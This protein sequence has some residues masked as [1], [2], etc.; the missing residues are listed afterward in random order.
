MSARLLDGRLIATDV[1][2]DLVSLAREYAQRH[3]RPAG[4]AIVEV[5]EHPSARVYARALVRAAESVGVQTSRIHLASS[6]S[7]HELRAVM[8]TLSTDASVQGILLVTPVPPQIGQAAIADV[9]A[10][11]KDVDG[12]S[13]RNA[14]N[15]FLSFPT[16]VP[17]TC[18]AVLELL[19]RAH[20]P[21]A[22][23]RVVVVGASNVVGKPLAYLLLQR[24]ATVTVCHV[25]TRNLP[26]L[27]RQAE[28]V[29]VAVGKPGIL[30]GEMIAPGAVVVDVGISVQADGSILGDVDT[31]SVLPVAGAL[32]PVPGGVGQLTNLMVLQQTLRSDA[33]AALP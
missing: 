11:N 5:G 21:L 7:E 13:F 28:I 25:H 19:D 3:G 17:S 16:F 31:A 4:L 33:L 29:V 8:L 10:P 30:T 22:G 27:T 18:A 26:K 24:D 12:I 6:A 20:I 15:L 14:G 2:A 32:T 23:K 1:R 9:I